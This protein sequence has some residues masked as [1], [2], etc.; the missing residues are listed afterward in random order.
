[1]AS[2][3]A[4]LHPFRDLESQAHLG[5]FVG[6]LMH[7][8]SI[9]TTEESRNGSKSLRVEAGGT[10]DIYIAAAVGTITVSVY[11][12]P[13]AGT[14]CGIMVFDPD[15]GAEMGTSDWSASSG[16]FEEL[17]VSFTSLGK[18]YIVRL[19]NREA[20]VS[21]IDNECYFDDLTVS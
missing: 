3:T 17:S 5:V 1:M 13:P 11:V 18:V 15:T 9:L 21:G 4:N 14:L 19:M 7:T 16:S 10:K 6:E 2:Y 20:F 8:S 12:K